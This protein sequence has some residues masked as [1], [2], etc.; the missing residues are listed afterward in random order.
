M[1]SDTPGGFDNPGSIGGAGR[2]RRVSFV[3]ALLPDGAL[4]RAYD[5]GVRERRVAREPGVV[6]WSD[7]Q[8]A[9]G[10]D[11]DLGE[12]RVRREVA[13]GGVTEGR[14]VGNGVTVWNDGQ[15][16]TINETP[17]PEQLPAM[18]AAAGGL[19]G[20]LLGL[21]LG[22]LFGLGAAGANLY[23][24][25]PNSDEYA[26]YAEQAMQQEQLRRAQ[27]TQTASSGTSSSTSSDFGFDDDGDDGDGDG[28]GGGD[29]DGSD[30]FG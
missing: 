24:L 5:T 2:A 19:R 8:G 4:E 22:G 11:L 30:S 13:D 26:L 15:L 9:Q 7:S 23:G 27:Q 20:L 16:I 17:L 3:D 1:T 18:P 12:G 10:R 21:G 6:E 14:Q 28:D 25:D 29:G